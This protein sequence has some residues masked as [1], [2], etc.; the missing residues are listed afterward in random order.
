[1]A[2]RDPAEEA[3]IRSQVEGA[4]RTMTLSMVIG[5]VVIVVLAVLVSSLRGVLILA[6]VIYLFGSLGTQWYLRRRFLGP[7]KG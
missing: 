2:E 6:G 3:A 1:M 7:L 4:L 5:L